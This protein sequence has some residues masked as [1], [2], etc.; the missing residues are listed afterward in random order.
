MAWWD[1]WAITQHKNL[2]YKKTGWWQAPRL[3]V[4]AKM[5]INMFILRR[6]LH[7]LPSWLKK[8]DF[9]DWI[10][11]W[12]LTKPEEQTGKTANYCQENLNCSSFR[13]N[14]VMKMKII[15]K[16][17]IQSS[18]SFWH[19]LLFSPRSCFK[20]KVLL[21]L[22]FFF[23]FKVSSEHLPDPLSSMHSWQL[24]PSGYKNRQ[25]IDNVTGMKTNVDAAKNILT[26]SSK[27]AWTSLMRPWSLL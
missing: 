14:C 27:L 15:D 9:Y 5:L 11:T 2:Q 1:T 10:S 21:L 12:G 23:S 3:P 6:I 16:S 22:L 24:G 8:F 26:P 19:H 7:I 13:L 25:G 17:I 4:W 20:F 18:Q